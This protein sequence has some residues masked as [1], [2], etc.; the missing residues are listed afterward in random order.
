MKHTLVPWAAVVLPFGLAACASAPEGPD[1]PTPPYV[2]LRIESRVITPEEIQFLG[3]VVIENKMRSPLHLEKVDFAAELHDK[4]ILA[5][6][7]DQ[8]QPMGSRVTR[9]VTLPI[10][11]SLK[12]LQDQLED[13]LAEESVRV[14]LHGTVFPVGFA[15]IPLTV[16]AVVPAP[17]L[18][19]VSFDGA[20][21][22]PVDGDFWVRLRV[23]NPNSFPL[24]FGSVESFL[25]L[26]GK[27]YDLLRSECFDQIAPGGT[28]PLVLAMHQTRGKG[29][30]ILINIAKHRSFDFV[31]GGSIQCQTPHG[32][33]LVPL[34]VSSSP[35]VA[36]RR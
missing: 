11:V 6:S 1:V 10:R 31:V 12:N 23:R 21:G 34:E 5:E 24:T 27:R 35:P 2:E 29:L 22:S 3:T 19:E 16:S 25:T 18:P 8:P 36:V 9:T 4:P 13:V 15:P 14:T 30:S 7:V 26:N 20:D 33:F 17:R 32:L 28:G